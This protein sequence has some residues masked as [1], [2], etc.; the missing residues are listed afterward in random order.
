[1][2]GYRLDNYDTVVR[3]VPQSFDEEI[4]PSSPVTSGFPQ[5]LHES[6]RAVPH[7]G[8]A[9]EFC[10]VDQHIVFEVSYIESGTALIDITFCGFLVGPL[11]WYLVQ[12]F[13]MHS[14]RH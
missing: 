12:C 7:C 10:G 13:W 3:G 8:K 11:L 4:T 2:E 6:H 1:M 9:V 14:N 5:S